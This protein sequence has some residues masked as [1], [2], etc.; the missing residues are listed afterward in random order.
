MQLPRLSKNSVHN[1]HFVPSTPTS[2]VFTHHDLAPRNLFLDEQGYLWLMDWQFS[3]WYP[4]YFEYASMQN[5]HVFASWS[6]VERLRWRIF[7]WISV[8]IHRRERKTLERVRWK[9]TRFPL[10]RKGKVLQEGAPTNALHLRKPGIKSM[11]SVIG[12]PA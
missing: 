12:R 11:R 10:G 7:T 3:G 2:L 4:I 6:W 9:L 1:Q 8:R 5:F